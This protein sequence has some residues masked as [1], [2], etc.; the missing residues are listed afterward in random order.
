MV[1]IKV[2]ATAATLIIAVSLCDVFEHEHET[3]SFWIIL[4][5]VGIIQQFSTFT[6]FIGSPVET[7]IGRLVFIPATLVADTVSV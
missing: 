5:T 2:T 6:Q 7:M 3:F 1:T 4:V